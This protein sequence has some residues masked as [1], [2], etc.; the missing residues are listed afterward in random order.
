MSD[1]L[2]SAAKYLKNG[3]DFVR[4]RSAFAERVIEHN[5]RTQVEFARVSSLDSKFSAGIW[6][7]REEF[8]PASSWVFT[9]ALWRA[10]GDW[11]PARTLYRT[12]IEDWL[13]RAWRQR[14]L[15]IAA[16]ECTVL[17]IR[18]YWRLAKTEAAYVGRSPEYLTLMQLVLEDAASLRQQL[19]AC[20]VAEPLATP[21]R[22]RR[23]FEHVKNQL[24]LKCGADL[25]EIRRRFRGDSP[26]SHIADLA[27][28]RTGKYLPPL[29]DIVALQRYVN[30]NVKQWQ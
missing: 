11:R 24:Y 13:L 21:S 12:P 25:T 6:D 26:G 10:V 18:T 19:A 1:H 28:R 30:E 5:G 27:F 22:S 29:P 2:E 17:N 20:P 8:E 16:H 9:R 3:Y 4:M 23:L 15:A 14:P 7:R